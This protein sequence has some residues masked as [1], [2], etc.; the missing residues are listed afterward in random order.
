MGI[1]YGMRTVTLFPNKS[2]FQKTKESKRKIY[3]NKNPYLINLLGIKNDNVNF[4]ENLHKRKE[5][6]V[7]DSKFFQPL[8]ILWHI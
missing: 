6:T 8:S 3:F 5:R 7:L 2:S 4:G 1:L